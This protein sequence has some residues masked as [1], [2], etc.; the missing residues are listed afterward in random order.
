MKLL[1]IKKGK[2]YLKLCIGNNEPHL[3]KRIRGFLF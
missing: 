3:S 2:P 1:T